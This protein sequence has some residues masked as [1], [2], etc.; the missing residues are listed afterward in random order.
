MA[1][2]ISSISNDALSILCEELQKNNHINPDYYNRFEV[3]RG[4]RNYD[5][6]GVLAGLTRVCSVEGYYMDDGEKVPKQGKL[7]YRGINM[8]DIVEHCEK[9]NRFGYEEVAWLLLFGA[10]PTKEQLKWFTELLSEC[11]NLPDDFIEDMIIKAPSPN[12]MNKLARSVLALY[13]YDDNPDDLSIENVLRQS[14]QIL[15]QLPTIMTYAYQVKRRHYY[16]KSMYLHS[17]KPNLST[18]ESILHMLRFNTNFTDEEAKLLR[19]YEGKEITLGVRPENIVRGDEVKMVVN[20]CENLGQT[21][22]VHGSLNGHKITA[23]LRE[24]CNIPC[25][26]ELGISFNRKHFFD[27][28]TTNAIR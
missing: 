6:T 12:I 26:D 9:E 4:L 14:L 11:R 23:K 18:A 8:S 21:T 7:V 19:P 17:L 2:Y 22:L 15:A 20:N 13:S 16:K 5:G 10:L 28:E 27:K 1:E 3:K 24:W 25:G